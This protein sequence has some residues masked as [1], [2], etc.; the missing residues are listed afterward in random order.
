[1]FYE[2]PRCAFPCFILILFSM[3]LDQLTQPNKTTRTSEVRSR[4]SFTWLLP[5]GLIIG[6]TL[7]ILLLFGDRLTPATE[8]TVSPVITL[9]QE[10]S[11]P[12][13]KPLQISKGSMLFQA[14]GWVEPDP[15][16]T[17]VT[18]LIDGIVDKVKVLEGQQVKKGDLL[19][20]LV[21]DDAKL[22]FQQATQ[23]IE[24]HE[25]RIEAHCQ[26]S[27]TIAA[28]LTGAKRKITA[29]QASLEEAQD[30]YQRF[31][32]SPSGAVSK[33]A[34]TAS[35][36]TQDRQAAL[37]AEAQA[38]IPRLQSRST[39][40]ELERITMTAQL[41]ELK[42]QRDRAKLALDRTKITAPMDGIIL[43][44]HVAPGKKRMLGMDDPKSAVIVELYDPNKLQ[45]RIDVPL[46]EAADMRAGQLVE[47]SS[48]LLPE[49]TFHAVVT[50][51]S[52]EADIQRN[53]LQAKVSIQNP[54]IRLRPGMLVRGK[55]FST[56][57]STSTGSSDTGRL[58]LY[59]PESA[60]VDDHTVWVVGSNQKAELRTIKLSNE[61]KDGHRRVYEGLRSGERV[62]LPPHDQLQSGTRLQIPK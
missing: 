18:T 56:G 29:L 17:Y 44:L 38:D 8:V 6:F 60:L 23:N 26:S 48:D 32:K 50:R 20:T 62:I 31:K 25:N 35:R 1:M 15:Y 49:M 43:H 14:S 54:D 28:E 7:I 21:D 47:L 33:Q 40:I 5:T 10:A 36:L 24:T 2:H 19:A 59:V 53:T 55:F 11:N 30:R 13:E 4:R 58:A 9:R 51:I 34:L 16:T 3:S 39:Q 27:D 37:V 22:N 52:G 12:S 42:I 57:K 61:S 41:S 46:S 45:A